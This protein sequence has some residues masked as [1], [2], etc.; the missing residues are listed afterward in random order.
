MGSPWVGRNWHEQ[1]WGVD[2]PGWS[3]PESAK[4]GQLAGVGQGVQIE[5]KAQVLEQGGARDKGG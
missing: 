4:V 2:G 3:G 5:A 1:R